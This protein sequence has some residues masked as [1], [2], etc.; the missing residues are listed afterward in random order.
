MA[1][2]FKVPQSVRNNAA[3]ALEKRQEQP[4]SNRGGTTPGIARAVQLR[5]ND[6]IDL[7][8]IRQMFSFFSRHLVDK[9]SKS[10]KQA[11]A[12]GDPWKAKSYQSWMLWGGDSGFSFA[13]RI[14]EANRGK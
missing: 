2:K 11:K 14:V 12:E 3:K 13:K 1:E 7:A 6:E 10:W 9:Q 8:T 4:P 5:D